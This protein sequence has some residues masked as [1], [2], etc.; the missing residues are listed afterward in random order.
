M[1]MSPVLLRPRRRAVGSIDPTVPT[2]VTLTTSPRE[3]TGVTLATAPLAPTGVGLTGSPGNLESVEVFAPDAPTG[4]TATPAAN[5]PSSPTGVTLSTAPSSPTGVGLTGQP[6]TP[7]VEEV[8][9]P[10]AP[11]SVTLTPQSIADPYFA[12]VSIL[13]QES[14]ADESSNGLTLTQYGGIAL[15]NATYKYGSYSLYFDGTD[16]YLQATVDSTLHVTTDFTIEFWMKS[17]RT[18]DQR[19][20]MSRRSSSSANDMLMVSISSQKITARYDGS[21]LLTS[22]TNVPDGNWHYVSVVK[23][24]TSFSIYIDGAVEDTASVSA[25]TSYNPIGLA[26]NIGRDSVGAAQFYQGHLDGFRFTNGVAR[27]SGSTHTV[28][29]ASL[30]TS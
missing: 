21:S 20:V 11:T 5:A 24:G 4:V 2:G 1:A 15:D 28:P 26:F 13:L 14:L 19:I 17:S 22:S 27:Y 9:V 12:D 30:P 8:F 16:D 18:S 23:G 25:L 6:G 29:V 10:D 7:T 3:P